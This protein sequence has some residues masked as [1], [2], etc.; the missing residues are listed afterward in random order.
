MCNI[1]CAIIRHA[2]ECL[3]T[4]NCDLMLSE[5]DVTEQADLCNLIFT[6]RKKLCVSTGMRKIYMY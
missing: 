2:L 4:E 5:K 3:V 6:K 1:I